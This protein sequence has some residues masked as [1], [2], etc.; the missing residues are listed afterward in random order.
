MGWVLV[1]HVIGF[2]MWVG[3]QMML[4]QMLAFHTKETDATVKE[5]LSVF[6]KKMSRISFIGMGVALV[7][8]AYLLMAAGFDQLNAKAH[9]PGFHIKLTCIAIFIGLSIATNSLVGKLAVGEAVKPSKFKIYHH[10]S[11]AVFIGILAGVLVMFR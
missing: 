10:V 11:N 3:G 8:G 7:S 1:L 2:V 9:G 6:E 4:T 5:S